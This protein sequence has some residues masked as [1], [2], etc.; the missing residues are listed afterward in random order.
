MTNTTDKDIKKVEQT[1]D[2]ESEMRAYT[3][4][5]GRILN[6]INMAKEGE[7]PNYVYIEG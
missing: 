5:T 6:R 1:D 2:L 4:R 3:A 7:E